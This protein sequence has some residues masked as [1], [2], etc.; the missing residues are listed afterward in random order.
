MRKILCL[1][2]VAVAM[3]AT[4]AEATVSTVYFDGAD[5]VAKAP[6]T[7]NTTNTPVIG[8]GKVET[9]SGAIRTYGTTADATAF[10][11]WI[12]GLSNPG[13]G[14]SSFNLWLQ[15]GHSNQAALWGET[16]ALSNPYSVDIHPFASAGWHAEVVSAPDSWGTWWAGRQIISYWSDVP[17]AYLSIGTSA[18]FGFT[19]DIIG[20]DGATGPNYQMWIGSNYP[21]GSGLLF[22][23]AIN[24]EVPEPASLALFGLALAGLAAARRRKA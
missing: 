20:N 17:D 4:Q 10:N 2:G 23:R 18:T 16:I 3:L 1:L 6:T 24:A 9:A 11:N 22:Q 12:D 5:I 7:V 13:S 19:A 14:I 21:T 8:D 15:D